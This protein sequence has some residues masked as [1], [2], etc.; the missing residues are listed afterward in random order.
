MDSFLGNYIGQELRWHRPRLMQR[1][2]EL[3]VEDQVLATLSRAGVFKDRTIAEIEG[4]KWTFKRQGFKI[5][6]YF[7]DEPVGEPRAILNRRWSGKG[8]LTFSD[9]RVIQWD[10]SGFWN[11]VHCWVTPEGLNVINL[12]R[13]HRIEI[14]PQAADQP[15]LPLLVAFGFYLILIAEEDAAAAA[16]TS[17]GA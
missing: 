12:K 17:A 7:G 9:G 16:S 6:V 5:K 1:Y 11:P 15:D 4:Q 13:G 8:E 10:R 3:R 2:Y 14:T